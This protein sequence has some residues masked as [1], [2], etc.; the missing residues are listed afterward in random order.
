MINWFSETVT[1]FLFYNKIM[2]GMKKCFNFMK[3]QVLKRKII[4]TIY[5]NNLLLKQKTK[6]NIYINV[7]KS[8][9]IF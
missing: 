8:T 6:K 1:M 4:Y 3:K 9:Y 2:L 7:F 5:K